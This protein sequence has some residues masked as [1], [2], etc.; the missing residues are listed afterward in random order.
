M[1]SIMLFAMMAMLV[2]CGSKDDTGEL[3]DNFVACT[4]SIE[5]AV[6]VKVYDDSIL[7]Q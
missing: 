3:E 5:F 6:Y 2:G 1:K 4:P 7:L